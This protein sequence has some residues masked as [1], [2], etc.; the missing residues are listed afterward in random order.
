MIILNR[1]KFTIDIEAYSNIGVSSDSIIPCDM[2]YILLLKLAENRRGSYFLGKQ[3][4]LN[5]SLVFPSYCTVSYVQDA[6]SVH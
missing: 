4:L 2:W 3:A 6:S 1:N 5:C